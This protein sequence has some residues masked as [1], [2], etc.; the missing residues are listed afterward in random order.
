MDDLRFF[1][2]FNSISVISGRSTGD[3][4]RLYVVEPRLRLK[5]SLLQSAGLE[6]RAATCV[7]GNAINCLT[8]LQINILY[9]I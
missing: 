1:V 6:S 5:R 3:N 9:K 2:L 8:N 7:T 4:E